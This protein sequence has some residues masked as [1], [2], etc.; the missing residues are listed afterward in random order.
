RLSASAVAR[1]RRPFRWICPAVARASAATIVP[2]AGMVSSSPSPSGPTWYTSRAKTGMSWVYD[3]PRKQTP[4]A[5]SSRPRT[6]GGRQAC[7]PRHQVG[8]ERLPSGCTQ[9]PDRRAYERVHVYV[10]DVYL[11]RAH[12]HGEDSIGHQL[13]DLSADDHAV[14]VD[15]IGHNAPDQGQRDE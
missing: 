13:G 3:R 9:S 2:A 4:A 14:A 5:A 10:D 15:A 8:H 6:L 7:R 11:A 12:Q 1:K